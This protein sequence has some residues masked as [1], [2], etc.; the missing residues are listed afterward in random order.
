MLQPGLMMDRPLLVSA[1]IEHAAAQYGNVEVVSRETHGPLFRY[2]WRD[3]A[4]RSRQLAN[5]LKGLGLEAGHVVGSIAWNNHRHLEAYYGVSGSGMIMHTVNPRLQ[6]QQLIYVINHAQDAAVMFDATFAP[7]IQ[8]IAAHCP[9]VKAWICLSDAANTPPIEG[10][11]NVHNYEDLIA[12]CSDQFD[13][14]EFDEKAG[15]ALCY[16]SGTTGNP[17]GVLYSHRALVLNALS[18]SMPGVLSLSPKDTVLPVVPMFH[19][20]AWCIPY[21]APMM[22]ARLVLPG[23]R[24]DGA[25]LHGLM[26]SE[27]VTVSAGVPTIWLGLVQFMEQN[28]LKFTTMHRTIVGGTAMP[29]ALIAK[30]AD[31]Y[32][33]EVHHGWG[34]TE[35]TAVATMGCLSPED[36][37]L[38]PDEQHA[39]IARQGKSL[40]CVDI[41]IVDPAGQTLPRDGVSQGELMVRGQWIAKAYF[42]SDESPLVDGWFPTGDIA[43]IDEHG[44]M[45]IRD[46][47]KDVIKSGGEWI[48]S[49]DLENAALG[50]PAV[51]LAAVIGVKHP[52]WDERPLMLVVRKPGQSVEKDD[53][54]AFLRDRVASWWLPEE[55]L[56]VDA[57][58][59]G[60]TGK[61]Q[62]G[63]LREKYGSIF[64]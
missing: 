14:P 61:V 37:S 49:I 28:G 20:N 47:T 54:L 45:Q 55:I 39:I 11:A 41:K 36:E 27:R 7:L 31:D 35:T 23:P 5:A 16:T 2:T 33:V 52:K 24:L 4:R 58:P 60:G 1:I 53:L 21:G 50:H 29:K 46:R 32:G 12:P 62:K 18:G 17:K 26:E 57:L 44:R 64:A 51:A 22:G 25:S 8:G 15:A 63:P 34:M 48:S 19:I 30:F 13:W 9:Q 59:V 38:S 6:V 42:R 43:T 56:F 40:F 3:C 10:V